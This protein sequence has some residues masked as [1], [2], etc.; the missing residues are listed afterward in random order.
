MRRQIDTGPPRDL[1]NR[2][3]FRCVAA[4]SLI[5]PSAARDTAATLRV[6]FCRARNS[7]PVSCAG[8]AASVVDGADRA[9]ETARR[10]G[11]PFVKARELVGFPAMRCAQI[12]SDLDAVRVNQEDRLAG[13]V[14]EVETPF[15]GNPR[16]LLARRR[17]VVS[18]GYTAK[19]S[20]RN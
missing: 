9:A 11:Q 8:S 2:L 13:R 14:G 4:L 3:N 6:R 7:R 17:F 16:L 10:N 18:V 5:R 15:D 20:R 12:R 19:W 1:P